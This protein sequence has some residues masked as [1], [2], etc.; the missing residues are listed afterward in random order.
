MIYNHWDCKFNKREF[1]PS[2][3]LQVELEV[4]QP[5]GFQSNWDFGKVWRAPSIEDSKRST[6][7]LFPAHAHAS[8]I[9]HSV[10]AVLVSSEVTDHR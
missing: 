3:E 8:R 10:S 7:T 1:L 5:V 9:L 2:L 6:W 4:M